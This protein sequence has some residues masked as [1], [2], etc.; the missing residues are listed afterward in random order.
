[1]NTARVHAILAKPCLPWPHCKPGPEKKR[2]KIMGTL[3]G[4]TCK[5]GNTFCLSCKL[6]SN[7]ESKY[8][9]GNSLSWLS[10]L[11]RV[12]TNTAC[13]AAVVLWACLP[14]I[15]ILV[16]QESHGKP[17]PCTLK[18]VLDKLLKAQE[19]RK[20]GWMRES[21]ILEGLFGLTEQM[22]F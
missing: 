1:M 17:E 3:L 21:K 14:R 8:Q 10:S 4:L 7:E 19:L 12:Q 20:S 13:P 11:A 15:T 2:A 16:F 9:S 22:E 18:I 6:S 5:H